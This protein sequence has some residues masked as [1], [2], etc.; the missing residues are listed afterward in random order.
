MTQRS[1][2]EQPGMGDDFADGSRPNEPI[3]DASQIQRKTAEERKIREQ[4]LDKTSPHWRHYPE[5]L[6]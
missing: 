2:D 6:D 1:F 3:L 4:W 5:I